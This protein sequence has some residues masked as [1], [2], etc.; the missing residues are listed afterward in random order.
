MKK[1]VTDA[2]FQTAR[3]ESIEIMFK[4]KAWSYVSLQLNVLYRTMYI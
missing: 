3:E 4:D 2:E 1:E